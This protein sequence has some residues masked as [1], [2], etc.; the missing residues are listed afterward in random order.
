MNLLSIP[1]IASDRENIVRNA[2]TIARMMEKLGIGAKLVS[3][4]GSNSVVVGEIRAPGAIPPR[5]GVRHQV[6][7][8]LA[9]VGYR[10]TVWLDNR[11]PAGTPLRR[12]K[13]LV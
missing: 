1:N 6:T 9:F 3:A 12:G 7:G 10:T 5:W 4:P 8:M 2:E 11:L 13:K